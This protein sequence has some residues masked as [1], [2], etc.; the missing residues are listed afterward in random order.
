MDRKSQ[1]KEPGPARPMFKVGGRGIPGLK[2][3][4]LV[5]LGKLERST[6]AVCSGVRVFG[7]RLK[8]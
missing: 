4:A 1:G 6:Q 7:R 5:G 2:P 8:V 3:K